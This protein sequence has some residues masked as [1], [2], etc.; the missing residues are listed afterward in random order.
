MGE[1]GDYHVLG[2][3]DLRLNEYRE[4]WRNSTSEQPNV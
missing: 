4:I 2:R 1:A 3:I